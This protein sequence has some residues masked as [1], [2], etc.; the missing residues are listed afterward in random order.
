MRQILLKSLIFL[1]LQTRCISQY[2]MST[3]NRNRNRQRKACLACRRRKSKCDCQRPVCD[4]CKRRQTEHICIYDDLYPF[5][6]SLRLHQPES[7]DPKF[8][9]FNIIHLPQ[10]IAVGNRIP[11]ARHYTE[12]LYDFQIAATR[13]TEIELS[14][15]L[16]H[17][18]K[19][20]SPKL[21]HEEKTNL[22]EAHMVEN[23][24]VTKTESQLS[25]TPPQNQR[26]KEGRIEKE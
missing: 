21:E 26:G 15:P 6:R 14:E 11:N 20:S 18:T 25:K 13:P 1:L 8:P 16:K 24:D 2:S 9:S 22:L 4:T 5:Q 23:L 7:I 17:E 19:E 3:S 10:M 12:S